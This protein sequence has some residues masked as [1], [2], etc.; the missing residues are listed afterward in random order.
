MANLKELRNERLRKLRALRQAGIDPY[1]ARSTRS[2]NAADVATDFRKLKGK[3][4]SVAGRLV[5]TRKFGKIAFFVLR[6]AS[7]Q[8]QLFLKESA[9]TAANPANS[10]LSFDQLGLLDP[11][12]FIEARG[13]VIKTATGEISVEVRKLRIL[14]KTIRPLPTPQEGFSDKEQRLRRRYIDTNVNR[15]VYERFVRRAAFWQAHRDFLNGRGFVEINLPILEHVTGGA[16]ANPFV[17]HMDALDQDFYLRISHELYIKRLIG[18][19]Y[20]RVYDIGPRFRNENYSDEHLPEHVAMEFNCAY[21]DYREGIE[22]AEALMKHAARTAFGSLKFKVGDFSVDLSKKWPKVAYADIMRRKMDVDVFDPDLRQLK[23]ILKKHKA[24]VTEEMNALRA[25]D[26]VWKLVRAQEAGPFWLIDEPIEISPLAKA[27]VTDRRVSERIHPV[28]AGTE[29]GNGYSELNDPVDQLQRMLEQQRLRDAGDKEAQMLDIDFI[30]MLE[31]GMPPN[32]GWGHSER[33]FWMLEGVTAREGVPFPQLRHE[34]DEVTKA[35][36]PE[37][38]SRK[39]VSDD[40]K[41]LRL[42]D[43]THRIVA[44]VDK[45]L[46]PWQV[47]NAVAHMSAIIGNRLDAQKLTT[48]EAF[49]TADAVALPRNSQYPIIVMRA[50]GRE[51]HKLHAQVADKELLHHVFVREMLDT[52]DDQAI[53]DSLAGKKV[54]QAVFYGVAFFAH[55]DLAGSLTKSFQLYE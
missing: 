22:M 26:G 17:T 37:V 16:D 25:L 1:P 18:G 39:A 8:V 41:T 48:G 42:Q 11:S 31:Y 52:T 29:A 5:N 24:Y 38:Y 14:T 32:F 7:G 51:L 10:E 50:A 21:A 45:D 36:Y 28:I 27:N 43:F 6:D 12:D 49:V 35:I 47:T 54:T 9:F 40:G 46:K 23:A 15:E 55:N 19:G 30:E 13:K 2:H 53:A 4:V 33:Y 44:V 20:E 34:I 3:A